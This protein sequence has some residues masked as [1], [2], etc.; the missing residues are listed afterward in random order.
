MMPDFITVCGTCGQDSRTCECH[1]SYYGDPPYYLT[2]DE[3]YE[4]EKAEYRMTHWTCEVC[5]GEFGDG[6]TTCDCEPDEIAYEIRAAAGRK[7]EQQAG[8]G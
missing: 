1:D 8:E 5:G 6:W 4:I 3:E 2:D 7:A